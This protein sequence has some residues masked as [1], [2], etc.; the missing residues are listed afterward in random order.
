MAS[1]FMV[2]DIY[3]RKRSQWSGKRWDL[4]WILK[5]EGRNQGIPGRG[6]GMDEGGNLVGSGDSEGSG[7][8]ETG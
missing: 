4:G 2:I 7:R 3:G 5:L 6:P 1:V 8:K